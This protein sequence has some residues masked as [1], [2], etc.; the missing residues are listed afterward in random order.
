[1]DVLRYEQ[2]S[3]LDQN[4]IA[5]SAHFFFPGSLLPTVPGS[6]PISPHHAIALCA[7]EFIGPSVT[8]TVVVVCL[9]VYIC[10]Y[11]KHQRINV[12][13]RTRPLINQEMQVSVAPL[14]VLSDS[15]ELTASASA[16]HELYGNTQGDCIPQLPANGNTAPISRSELQMQSPQNAAFPTIKREEIRELGS[17]I[18]RTQF[19]DQSRKKCHQS[20]ITARA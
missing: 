16:P 11:R 6:T 1:V 5:E 8:L 12:A 3:N 13:R 10:C 18:C 9:L 17:S 2:A 19:A 4:E 15:S 7:A 20:L 14:P